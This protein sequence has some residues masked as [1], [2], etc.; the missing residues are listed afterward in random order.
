MH[1]ILAIHIV[2]AKCINISVITIENDNMQLH[3]F[4]YK[5]RLLYP[6]Y[7]AIYI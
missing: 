6:A 5:M 2:L 1:L 3:L 7:R 4:S